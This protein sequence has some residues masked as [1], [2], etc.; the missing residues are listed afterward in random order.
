MTELD[1]TSARLKKARMAAGYKFVKDFCEKFNIPTS[2]YYLHESG[3]RNLKPK[4]AKKYADF[5]AVNVVWLLTG[6]GSPYFSNVQEGHLSHEEFEKML[7]Y[8]GH[9]AVKDSLQSKNEF[10]N[11]VNPLIFC[12]IIIKLVELSIELNIKLETP[13]LSKKSVEIYKDITL[14]CS[15]QETQLAMI[16]LSITTF[17]R[18]MNELK[19]KYKKTA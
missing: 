14:S 6:T 18:Q 17:K 1:H 10:L 15:E 11:N 19:G 5:L 4:V 9:D 16:S 13:Y 12:S 7:G 2:T 8:T 3:L